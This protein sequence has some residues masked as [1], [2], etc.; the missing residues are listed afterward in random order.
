MADRWDVLI[1][2]AGMAG[3]PTAIRAAERGART[4]VVEAGPVI[5][6]KLPRSA[7]QISA[8]GARLQRRR[9]IDDSA[10]D[11]FREIM[12]INGGTG[13]PLLIRL[14]VEEAGA[15]I[16]WLEDIGCTFGPEMPVITYTHDLYRTRRYFWPVRQGPEILEAFQR[17][18]A[19]LTASGGLTIRT[20]CEMT[21]FL[22]DTR[23][24]TG[25]TVRGAQGEE[26]LSAT[27]V[28]LAA[29]GYNADATLAAALTPQVPF[30]SPPMPISSGKVLRL[31]R[32][33][34]CRLDG[35]AEYL[36]VGMGVLDD[37][38]DRN[39]VRMGLKLVPQQRPPWEI[40]VNSHGRRFTREDH[41]KANH[42]R[43]AIM[44]QPDLEFFIVFDEGV[45]QNA[46]NITAHLADEALRDAFGRHPSYH[47]AADVAGLARAIGVDASA[48]GEAIAGYNDAVDRGAGDPFGRDSLPRPLTKPPYY[49]I[50]AVGCGLPSPAGIAI[51]SSLRA[52]A[53]D[54]RPI[55]GLYAAGE[56][57]GYTR[58]MGAA[59]EAGMGNGPAITLARVLGERILRW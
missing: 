42:R 3:L 16:D 10:E 7:G 46:P 35:G 17:R 2:G 23:R 57:F 29:G 38:D 43:R 4:L 33:F 36:C 1:V 56:I 39:S 37:P 48:L 20:H 24:V 32:D 30:Y 12:A 19:A 26:R 55:P 52:L 51:D 58:V 15:T 45:R 18:V 49:A 31:A 6:G 25:I 50:S 41:P 53:N 8:A 14:S 34:G 21:A 40:W 47:R 22:G 44:A 59:Y 54:G 28:V 9:G 13:D 11:H 27:N 5:G